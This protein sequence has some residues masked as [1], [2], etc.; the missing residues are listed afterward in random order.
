M[1]SDI[2][3]QDMKQFCLLF[4]SLNRSRNKIAID[5]EFAQRE[6]HAS[7]YCECYATGSI[8]FCHLRLD[9]HVIRNPKSTLRI[10]QQ[11]LIFYQIK[12]IPQKLHHIQTHTNLY[13]LKQSIL[14]TDYDRFLPLKDRVEIGSLGSEATDVYDD[15]RDLLRLTSIDL[16]RFRLLGHR[17]GR[18]DYYAVP[19]DTFDGLKDCV[20]LHRPAVTIDEEIISSL[21]IHIGTFFT[22][23]SRPKYSPSSHRTVATFIYPST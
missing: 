12:F 15:Q 11:S 13:N 7:P 21:A 19:S 22:M 3:C 23:S 10:T 20:A 14:Y 8:L 1:K 2:N 4:Q 17:F 5:P 16:Y 9:T 18:V 6:P